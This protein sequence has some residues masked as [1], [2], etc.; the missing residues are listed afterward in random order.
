MV[1]FWVRGD[2]KDFHLF[3]FVFVSSFGYFQTW[4]WNSGQFYRRLLTIFYV[5][6]TIL[7]AFLKPEIQIG[8]K[9]VFACVLTFHVSQVFSVLLCL[10]DGNKTTSTSLWE[11]IT[12][13]LPYSYNVVLLIPLQLDVTLRGEKGWPKVLELTLYFPQPIAPCHWVFKIWWLR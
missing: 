9:S 7:V 10:H 13:R 11:N 3:T 4:N 5:T 1:L 2:G 6:S 12:S 8:L